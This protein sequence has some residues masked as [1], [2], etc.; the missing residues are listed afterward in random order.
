MVRTTGVMVNGS[1]LRE[2]STGFVVGGSVSDWK[3]NA[4]EIR[5][6][7]VSYTHLDVYKRQVSIRQDFHENTG[8]MSVDNLE[9]IVTHERLSLIHI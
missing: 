5:V 7:P 8:A 2:G 3:T 9:G 1:D 4:P 6:Y